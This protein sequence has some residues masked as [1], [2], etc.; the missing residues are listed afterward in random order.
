M[1]SHPGPKEH[2]EQKCKGMPR[3]G[4]FGDPKTVKFGL[5]MYVPL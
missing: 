4:M 5:L 2:K 3:N 1:K